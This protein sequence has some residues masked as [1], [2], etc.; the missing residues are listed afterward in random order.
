MARVFVVDGVFGVGHKEYIERHEAPRKEHQMTSAQAIAEL[1]NKFDE[2]R[3][4]WIS[5]YGSDY[6]FN[7]WFTKQVMG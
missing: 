6:G 1:M 4:K 3:A 2:N 7:E 5:Q